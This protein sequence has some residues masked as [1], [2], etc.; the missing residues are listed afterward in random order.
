VRGCELV[1]I[2]GKGGV[3]G[4]IPL[5]VACDHYVCDVYEFI[6]GSGSFAYSEDYR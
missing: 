5:C 1:G 4:G 6:R 2:M 3:G